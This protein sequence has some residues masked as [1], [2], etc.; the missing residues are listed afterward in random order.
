MLASSLP[1]RPLLSI[2]SVTGASAFCATRL[3]SIAAPTPPTSG[4][5]LPPAIAVSYFD[6][7]SAAATPTYFTLMS[8][9]FFS[10]LAMISFQMS[11][12][13]PPLLSQKVMVPL[14]LP[15]LPLPLVPSV[16]QAVAVRASADSAATAVTPVRSLRPSGAVIVILLFRPVIAVITVIA[17]VRDAVRVGIT[18]PLP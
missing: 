18:R 12:R 7:T 3:A 1:L 16:P 9:Y 17:V 14:P 13:T 10:N 6:C 11:V 5:P 4:S 2:R 8:G 15:S